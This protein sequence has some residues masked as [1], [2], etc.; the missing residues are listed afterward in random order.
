M[1]PHRRIDVLPFPITPIAFPAESVL[2]S[3]PIFRISVVRIF[4]TLASL[5]DGL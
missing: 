3:N 2:A 1:C 5:P 4:A